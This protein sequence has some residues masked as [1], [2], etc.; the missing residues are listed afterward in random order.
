MNRR[1]TSVLGLTSIEQAVLAWTGSKAYQE[2]CEAFEGVFKATITPVE[3]VALCD[4]YRAQVRLYL[5]D[6]YGRPIEE[7]Q[8]QVFNN[9]SM[10]AYTR[11]LAFVTTI[12]QGDAAGEKLTATML[13]SNMTDGHLTTVTTIG[14]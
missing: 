10:I 1:Q 8:I 4:F 3:F 5:E 13:V 6:F 2:A 9:I 12:T 14:R 11:P 7:M